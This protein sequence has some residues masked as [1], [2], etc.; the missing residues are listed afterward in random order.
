[1]KV[2]NKRIAW[3]KGLNK[4]TDE[5]IKKYS[6]TLSKHPSLKKGR[7]V[8]WGDKI[9]KSKKGKPN[10]IGASNSP[11]KKGSQHIFWKGGRL[12]HEGYIMIYTPDHPYANKNYVKEHRLVM[13]KKLKRYLEKWEIIHH[14]NGIKD[15]NRIE[16]LEIVVAKKHFGKIRCPHCLK[17]FLIK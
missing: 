12:K 9:S 17:K 8:T 15:D 10:P 16:N 2:K 6:I 13:E 3:N 14:K 1:M 4:N 7:K 5:R 11:F